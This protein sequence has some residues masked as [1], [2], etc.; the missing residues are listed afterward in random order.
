VNDGGARLVAGFEPGLVNLLALTRGAS[1]TA[2][3][4]DHR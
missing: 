1:P 3:V 2:T 4:G